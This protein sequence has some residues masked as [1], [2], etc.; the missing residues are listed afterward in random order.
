MKPRGTEN[1]EYVGV[2]T[3]VLKRRAVRPTE[4]P[5]QEGLG[6]F[7]ALLG[8][9]ITTEDREGFKAKYDAALTDVFKSNG[10]RRKKKCYK[11]AHLVK[12][13]S[14]KAPS[15]IEGILA[16]LDELVSRIDIY[17]AYYGQDFIS[18]YGRARGE[19]L[20][21]IAFINKVQN[22][23]PHVCAWKY[24]S[25][26]LGLANGSFELDHFE[27]KST[28]AWRDL[29]KSTSS[30]KV[31]H[32]GNECNAL[33]SVSDLVLK[34][35]DTF[36]RGK[37]SGKSLVETLTSRLPTFENRTYYHNLGARTE[38][39]NYSA[40]DLPFDIDTSP[41]F[42]HPLYFL[43]W[44]PQAPRDIVK[45]S[46]EWS[47]VYNRVMERAFIEDGS[48]K[49]LS[50]DRDPIFWDPQTDFLVPWSDVDLDHVRMLE[51][52][53]HELPRILS[54]EELGAKK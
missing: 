33:I 34:Y 10:L 31:F 18:I 44:N 27:G 30:I 7:E 15:I 45:P 22:A 16:K 1:L 39:L 47:S 41:F 48:V 12:Q 51:E 52:M 19:R 11:A 43:V 23:F 3:I 46:F 50:F 49:F 32:S 20:E 26:V 5:P 25:R 24:L 9:S 42:K 40:P 2:D 29:S 4:A 13:V 53:G 17:C 6:F 38:D 21:P 36:H 28:P 35:V 37:V 14:D 54:K 8:V